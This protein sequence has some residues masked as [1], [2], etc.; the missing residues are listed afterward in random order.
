MNIFKTLNWGHVCFWI[1]TPMI[2]YF[3]YNTSNDVLAYDSLI[4][5]EGP[6]KTLYA[7]TRKDIVKYFNV[8]CNSSESRKKIAAKIAFLRSGL[9]NS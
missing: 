3:P 5:C 2:T 9:G 1:K 4:H 6:V 7:I 8:F